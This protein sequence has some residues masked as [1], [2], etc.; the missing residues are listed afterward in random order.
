MA[1]VLLGHSGVL[2]GLAF[3][4]VDLDQL[5]SRNFKVVMGPV[6]CILFGLIIAYVSY[7]LW[8]GRDKSLIGWRLYAFGLLGLLAGMLLQ[9]KRLPVDGIT[10]AVFT[11][12]TT[13]IIYGGIM[14]LCALVISAGTPARKQ[15]QLRA[16]G[17]LYIRRTL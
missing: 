11:F 9:R 16:A 1:D 6:I 15:P 13:F 12:F 17:S 10:L 4:K 3:N 2:A 8:P 14:N 5:K 7:Q